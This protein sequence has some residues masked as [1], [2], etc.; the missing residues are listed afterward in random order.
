MAL[1]LVPYIVIPGNLVMGP[2]KAGLSAT[3]NNESPLLFVQTANNLDRALGRVPVRRLSETN[4]A[5]SCVIAD[6]A[7]GIPPDS[8]L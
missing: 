1:R 4:K 3:Q 2:H 8:W 6:R 5:V 7:A